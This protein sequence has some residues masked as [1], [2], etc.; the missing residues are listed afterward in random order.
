MCYKPEIILIGGNGHCKACINVV[1][2]ENKYQIAG[3]ID[4][5]EKLGQKILGYKVIGNDE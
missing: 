4:V 1:E 3:I 5:P 2:Q